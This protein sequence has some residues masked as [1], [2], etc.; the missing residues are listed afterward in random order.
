MYLLVKKRQWTAFPT[1]G[2]HSYGN[3][4]CPLLADYEHDFL[5]KR[6]KE[7]KRKLARK[8]SLS[9][10]YIDDLISFN[11]ERFKGVHF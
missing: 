1:D 2:W 11:N 7:G 10:R 3:K 4:L 8:F 9:Y 6:I 5:D